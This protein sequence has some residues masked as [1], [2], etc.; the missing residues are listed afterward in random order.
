M[1]Q[2]YVDRLQRFVGRRGVDDAMFCEIARLM[3]D[4]HELRGSD[5]DRAVQARRIGAASGGPASDRRC[6]KQFRLDELVGALPAMVAEPVL[7]VLE[8]L[9]GCTSRSRSASA[10]QAA[11]AFA[12]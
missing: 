12:A 6:R 1:P 2:L 8:W 7:D 5:P 10:R 3:A 4:A 9:G 11:G